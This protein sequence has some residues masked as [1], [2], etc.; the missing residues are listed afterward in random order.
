M[1]L[2]YTSGTTGKPKGVLHV[3]GAIVGQAITARDVLDLRADDI[4]WCTADPG[5]VTGTPM[6]SWGP[7]ANG[8]TQ[9]TL[10]A[11][12]SSDLWYQIIAQEQV[13][14]WYTSP[15]ALRLLKRDGADVAARHDLRTSGTSPASASR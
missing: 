2:H 6:A 11:G 5:W 15:T 3:H 8:I 10:A 1:L 14:V 7:W 9:V 12:Y 4:Y 13:T